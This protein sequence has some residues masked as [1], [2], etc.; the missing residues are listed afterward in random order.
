MAATETNRFGCSRDR[1]MGSCGGGLMAGAE[2][3]R[4]AG[5]V[6]E[7]IGSGMPLLPWTRHM[8]LV[9]WDQLRLLL[10]VIYYSFISVFQMFRFEVHVRI[11]DDPSITSDPSDPFLLS[12]LTD[13]KEALLSTLREDVDSGLF[14]GHRPTTSWAVGDWSF[15]VSDSLCS[16]EEHSASCWSSEEEH[17]MEFDCD[18]SKALWESLCVRNNDPY[19][20]MCFSACVSTRGCRGGTQEEAGVREGATEERS[21]SC[22]TEF[23]DVCSSF[24]DS[25][26]V[27]KPSWEVESISTDCCSPEEESKVLWEVES[28][29]PD[30]FSPEEES[31]ASWEGESR[32]PEAPLGRFW[33]S[34]SE[35]SSD[36]EEERSELGPG[37]GSGLERTLLCRCDS[38]S[39]WSSES[40][41]SS[42][43]WEQ[44]EENQLIWDLLSHNNDPFNPLSFSAPC[45]R[46][47][48]TDPYN[49]LRCRE[50]GPCAQAPE[51]PLP[52]KRRSGQKPELQQRNIQRHSH[53]QITVQHWRRA[54]TRAPRGPSIGILSE[55]PVHQLKK[56]WF[57]DQV[58]V[59]V[60][61]SW[62]WARQ[63]ARRG[64]WEE[65]AR[66]RERFRRRIQEA[67]RILGPCL[68]QEV[69]DQRASLHQD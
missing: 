15:F 27:C 3:E 18:E 45:S 6:M 46:D 14:M 23:G 60:M 29:S 35:E 11:T 5:G 47:H 67:E 26:D 38:N 58:Q 68:R 49:P 50:M 56:V 40:S 25:P 1:A 41:D 31:K 28:I 37:S 64:Q 12:T 30:C 34:S 43:T 69:R 2:T 51:S 36:D 54:P 39:S 7:R 10:H 17:G 42:E 48:N 52:R 65:S 22:K 13:H 4:F 44:R 20:P 63:A 8:L 19:D 32:H 55:K 57:S 16:D 24:C 62:R 9:L 53:P 21:A 59:H 61:R 66:D 33:G